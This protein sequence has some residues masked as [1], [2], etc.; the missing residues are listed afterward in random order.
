[1]K[2]KFEEIYNQLFKSYGPQNWWPAETPY[3]MMVGAVLTQNTSWN[4]VKR[5][6]DNFKGNLSPEFID[7][8]TDEELCEYIRP[9][10]FF[11]MKAKRLRGLNVWYS[12]YGY[13]A[14]KA[15][16]EDTIKLRDEL[17]SVSGIGRET[18]D[19]I[20]LYAF[21]KP[22]FVIDA[23][24]RRV[25]SRFGFLIPDD[26]DDIRRLFEE[27]LKKDYRLYNEYHA[28]I[29]NHAKLYCKKKPAC[30]D[31]PLSHNCAKNGI[32]KEMDVL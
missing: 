22:V 2:A 26:Y 29:V 31:C 7:N 13:D 5:A 19:S 20:L 12:K 4:N 17:L 14:S 25:F 23:Y 10:G 32:D 24:T 9:S 1:M 21:N 8:L 27:N 16:K 11:N 3:E 30:K 6:I 28:L 15:E 18:A